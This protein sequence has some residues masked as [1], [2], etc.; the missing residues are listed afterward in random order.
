MSTTLALATDVDV[1]V[2]NALGT[3]RTV[4]EYVGLVAFAISGA[5]AAGRKRMDLAGAVVLACLVAVGGGT[6]RDVMLD[7]PVFWMK[8]PSFLLVSAG[9]GLAVALLARWFHP[10]RLDRYRIVTISDALGLAVFVAVGTGIAV[11][12]GASTVTAVAMGVITG[13]GGGII[14][15]ILA[16]DVPDVLRNGQIYATAALAGALLYAILIATDVPRTV[17]VWAPIALV[18]TLRLA[19]L[20]FKW[21]VPTMGGKPVD[22]SWHNHPSQGTRNES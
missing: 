3:L 20:R 22:L 2:T 1:I 11:D 12:A 6:M 7:V 17:A 15:D 13:V 5:I 14:R 18:L 8:Q 4:L 10:N 16:N 19:S 21:G 9:V